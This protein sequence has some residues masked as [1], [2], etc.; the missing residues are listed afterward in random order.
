MPEKI[1][2]RIP[3]TEEWDS[4]VDI[5][6]GDN[7]IIHWDEMLSWVYDKVLEK[8]NPEAHELRGYYLGRIQRS[9]EASYRYADVGFR[10]AFD[11][12]NTGS[13]PSDPKDGDPIVIG[14]LYMDGKP[15]RVPENPMRGGD[16]EKYIP[17][18]TLTFGLALN[19][20][21][22]QVTAIKVGDV[23]I[24]DRVLLVDISYN[25]I[26]STGN[27]PIF[28]NATYNKYTD[29]QL[30]DD[31]LRVSQT[32]KGI[33]ASIVT[34][35]GESVEVFCVTHRKRKFLDKTFFD[36]ILTVAYDFN[37]PTAKEVSLLHPK[38][39]PT[40]VMRNGR[41]YCTKC[42]CW[43]PNT[44]NNEMRKEGF[45]A[46]SHICGIRGEGEVYET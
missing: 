20:P 35:D 44:A 30:G 40:V 32:E 29:F 33:S 4:F 34:N 38:D 13:C 39:R 18:T 9:Y 36:N 15:V 24:A 5:T 41:L 42:C 3:T 25:D 45:Y 23:F 31:V 6:H 1:N 43:V 27:E 17:G 2:M 12:L 8:Q 28:D 11:N 19:D 7:A 46:H 37:E 14:T 21:D 22:Y 16:V 26:K 10:P